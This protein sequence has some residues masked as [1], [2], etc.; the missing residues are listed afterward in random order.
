M[1]SQQGSVYEL[2][3]LCLVQ[4]PDPKLLQLRDIS[5]GVLFCVQFVHLKLNKL[6]R[7]R[8][9]NLRYLLPMVPH[10]NLTS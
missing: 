2:S 9:Y 3:P 4:D 7:L 5:P 1:K 10:S 8:D 6:K